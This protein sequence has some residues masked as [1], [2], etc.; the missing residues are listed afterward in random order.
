M[1]KVSNYQGRRDC[2]QRSK[3][4]VILSG[5]E[6]RRSSF[7]PVFSIPV[8]F[9][10]AAFPLAN[11]FAGAWVALINSDCIS[12][13]TATMHNSCRRL[14]RTWNQKHQ[15]F[16]HKL[17]LMNCNSEYNERLRSFSLSQK[18]QILPIPKISFV[19]TNRCEQG[20]R[21]SLKEI[22]KQTIC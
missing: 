17:L 8:E 6:Y 14:W 18:G 5:H 22:N 3:L 20:P 15:R 13:S 19:W 1:L 4:G 12:G 7:Y 21:D 11:S 10:L 2:F 16:E 9:V